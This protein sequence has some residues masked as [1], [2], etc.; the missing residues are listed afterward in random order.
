VRDLLLRYQR[1][2]MGTDKREDAAFR[3]PMVRRSVDE[4]L[5]V[6]ADEMGVEVMRLRERHRESW[7]RPTAA[8]ALQRH[9]GLNQREVAVALRLGTGAAV[10]QQLGQLEAPSPAKVLLAQPGS[11]DRRTPGESS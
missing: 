5:A 1:L 6:V 7:L 9:G 11:Q 3:K 2:V 8:W 10:S 4:L